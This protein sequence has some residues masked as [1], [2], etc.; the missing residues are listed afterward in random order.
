MI[1]AIDGPAGSGKSTVA[2]KLA[3]E[4]GFTY[5]DSGAMYRA[6]ALKALISKSPLENGEL[7]G[8]LATDMKIEFHNVGRGRQQVIVDDEDVT[9]R[10]RQPD[11][12]RAASVVAKYAQVRE[13][14]VERQRAILDVGDHIVEGRDIGTVVAPDAEVKVFLSADES[15]RARRRSE[16]LA[17]RGLN[18]E[19][20]NVL[21]AIEKRDHDDMTRSESPL[22][23]A[24]DAITLDTTGLSVDETVAKIKE[25]VDG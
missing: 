6:I 12:S 10:I 8:K 2:K 23:A 15:V 1:I 14:L 9:D 16:E 24:D 25:M 19:A 3:E 5:L 11:V 22:R 18:V 17:R 21:K 7:L 4:L 13:Q 20:D